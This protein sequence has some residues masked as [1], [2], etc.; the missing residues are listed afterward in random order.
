VYQQV[1][2]R[3]LASFRVIK[4]SVSAGQRTFWSGFDSRQLHY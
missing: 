2:S 3:P 1:A 4:S